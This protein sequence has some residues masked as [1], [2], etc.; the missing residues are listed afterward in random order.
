[1]THPTPRQIDQWMSAQDDLSLSETHFIQTHLERC[2]NCRTHIV[3]LRS[4]YAHLQT[5][6]SGLP[7]E[8]DIQEANRIIA[9]TRIA[10]PIRFHYKIAAV[11]AC[12]ALIGAVYYLGLEFRDTL[13]H[14]QTVQNESLIEISKPSDHRPLPAGQMIADNFSPSVHLEDLVQTVFRSAA[15][16]V[17]TPTIG[18]VVH[19]PVQFTWNIAASSLTLKIVSN[20]EKTLLSTQVQSHS[21]VMKKKLSPGLY[22]WKLETDTEL[23]FVGKFVVIE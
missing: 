8:R 17:I 15:I 23:L 13:P 11:I 3:L 4:F 1:M 10:Q 18:E 21:Y 2:S 20:H 7:T 12:A 5:H 22:Y 9:T 16:D 6:I 19:Q 14:S